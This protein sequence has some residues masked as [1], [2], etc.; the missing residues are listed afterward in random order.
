[1]N[2]P[3]ALQSLPACQPLLTFQ[4]QIFLL[5]KKRKKNRNKSIPNQDAWYSAL[6]QPLAKQGTH[7]AD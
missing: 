3:K 4:T 1:M 2:N 5:K 6:K 7:H